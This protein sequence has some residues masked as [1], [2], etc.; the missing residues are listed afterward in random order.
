MHAMN[1]AQ[2]QR[3]NR[4]TALVDM[5]KLC[6]TKVGL[7]NGWRVGHVVEICWN[8]YFFFQGGGLRVGW[9]AILWSLV[10]CVI[11]VPI[12]TNLANR[13]WS[14]N[15]GGKRLCSVLLSQ[16]TNVFWGM[17]V[18]FPVQ[19][20]LIQ[21]HF[22]TP[23][24]EKRENSF[25]LIWYLPDSYHCQGPYHLCI[26]R[27]VYHFLTSEYERPRPEDLHELKNLNSRWSAPNF[28]GQKYS[29]T[30]PTTTHWQK[31]EQLMY[32]W[33]AWFLHYLA[34]VALHFSLRK[35]ILLYEDKVKN[36]KQD[37]LKQT[38]RQAPSFWVFKV[39]P[40]S[41]ERFQQFHSKQIPWTSLN[42]VYVDVSENRG[43]PKWMVYCGK[44]Y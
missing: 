32:F 44:P 34:F 28:L 17:F 3:R 18:I 14:C 26:H 6:E 21:R 8:P 7:E 37:S 4:D 2:K 10:F 39:H 31:C 27:W 5:A 36:H 35:A 38:E 33:C 19:S 25:V 43:T 16:I 20:L 40:E 23:Q 15:N 13:D 11:F 30:V 1:E 29:N 22:W 41:G 24:M 42:T 12:G 9:L